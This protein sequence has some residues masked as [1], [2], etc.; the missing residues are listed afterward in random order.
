MRYTSQQFYAAPKWIEYEFDMLVK[1]A[2]LHFEAAG[3]LRHAP[4]EKAE[5]W[6][7]IQTCALEAF[8]THYRN[9]KQF[10][11]N[12][13]K[14]P[15]DVLASDFAPTWHGS[16]AVKE[17]Y[18]NEEVRINRLLAHISYDRNDLD[19]GNWDVAAMLESIRN[20]FTAYIPTIQAELQHG[21][22]RIAQALKVQK[23]TL[24]LPVE[25]STATV[26]VF[27]FWWQ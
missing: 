26:R 4:K 15:T 16:S 23:T 12:K 20:A 11:N 19:R 18:S 24:A 5:Y 27:S 6:R 9:L 10:L 17:S 8:L 7:A 14:F 3:E 25:N 13:K 21:F 22:S 2:R 1:S